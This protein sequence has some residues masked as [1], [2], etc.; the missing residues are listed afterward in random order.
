MSTP[1]TDIP[2]AVL[3]A[4]RVHHEILERVAFSRYLN[5]ANGPAARRT[6]LA[7]RTAA[8][9]FEYQPLLEADVLLATL[10]RVEPPRDHPAGAI[11]GACLDGTRIMIR[12]L[13]D[14]TAAAFDA[15]A[16]AGGWYPD[17]ALL[18]LRFPA[19][20]DDTAPFDVSS[21]ELVGHLESALAQRGMAG[22]QVERDRVM[23]ARVLV[24][25]AKR[26][27]RVNPDARFRQRDLA[28]LVVHEIDV[29]AVRTL[30]GRAQALRCFETGLP[31][32][33]AT[34]EGLAMLAEEH[35]GLDS[36]GVLSRQVE[37]VQAIDHA[38]R[39]GFRE[40]YEEL[41][42]RVGPSLAWGICLRIKRGLR[43][44]ED[45]G[46]Y[47]KDSVYLEGRQRVRAWLRCGGDLGHLYV[48]KVGVEDPVELWLDQ[49]WV[50]PRP[51]PSL[52][53]TRG[54]RD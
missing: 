32:A 3:D 20:P 54:R 7:G 30:N 34:E 37:V 5:P 13:R 16:R 19:A 12:A 36:P 8:P 45:P 2:A 17:R 40:V 15:M 27:L 26:L 50:Q 6:F 11:V 4:D 38:R 39:A 41:S 52:W 14:R 25:G 29:H 47:A 51:V 10:D 44:P 53:G 35:T 23:A 9:P 28:R 48:G 18:S 31:G 22:W 1:T 43:R 49:G 24:D 42:G 21:A 33:L 46:V